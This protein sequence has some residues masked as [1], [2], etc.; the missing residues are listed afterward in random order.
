MICEGITIRSDE[1]D[2]P[3]R[4]ATCVLDT[5]ADIVK[6]Q[7]RAGGGEEASG[8]ASPVA[9]RPLPPGEE[10]HGESL[11]YRINRLDVTS[12]YG[13]ICILMFR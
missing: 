2:I 1:G 4:P 3:Y 11:F 10:G 6:G 5:V 13:F 8:S 7:S 12:M 9:G